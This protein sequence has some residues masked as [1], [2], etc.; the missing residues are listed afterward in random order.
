MQS[1]HSE[2]IIAR[3]RK[4][5]S[6]LITDMGVY[7]SVVENVVKMEADIGEKVQILLEAVPD[8]SIIIAHLSLCKS[9]N[10]LSQDSYCNII[11]ECL[12]HLNRKQTYI[13]FDP[14]YSSKVLSGGSE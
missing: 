10:L 11:K 9:K 6:T 1:L 5:A 13:E 2:E 12:L 8:L 4:I 3:Q 7:R 14:T